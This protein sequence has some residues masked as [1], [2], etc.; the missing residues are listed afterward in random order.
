MLFREQSSGRRALQPE[1]SQMQVKVCSR[2]FKIWQSGTKNI[3]PTQCYGLVGDGGSEAL[4][5]TS[6]PKSITEVL[7][8][9]DRD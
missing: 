5:E 7:K 4:D 8:R 3:F 1:I 6:A 2:L 9:D